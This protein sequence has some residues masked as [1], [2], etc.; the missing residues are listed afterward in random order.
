MTCD[1]AENCSE[2]TC[3]CRM[4]LQIDLHLIQCALLIVA[5]KQPLQM[6]QTGLV[7][8]KKSRKG[9]KF[10]RHRTTPDLT[11]HH[12]DAI[13]AIAIIAILLLVQHAALDVSY[14]M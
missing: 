5:A 10:T 6:C 7:L 14:I 9:R 13:I 8:K 3:C 12:C 11:A 4:P 2:Y 1:S